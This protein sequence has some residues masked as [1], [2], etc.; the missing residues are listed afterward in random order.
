MEEGVFLRNSQKISFSP[1]PPPFSRGLPPPLPVARGGSCGYGVHALFHLFFALSLS[2]SW[3]SPSTEN[4]TSPLS[5]LLFFSPPSR[6][7][8]N[9]PPTGKPGERF[10]FPP[11]YWKKID[12]PLEL[13]CR[14]IA[15]TRLKEYLSPFLRHISSNCVPFLPPSSPYPKNDKAR[16]M[17]M[18]APPP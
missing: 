8:K 2:C 17:E 14:Y 5:N 12:G 6:C 7:E 4:S 10:F 15:L 13:N 16:P 9:P 3:R 18:C 11:L 1:P